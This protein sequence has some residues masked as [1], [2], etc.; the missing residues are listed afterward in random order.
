M[1]SNIKVKRICVYCSREFIAQTTSTKYCSKKCNSAHYKAKVRAKKVE[2]SNIETTQKKHKPIQDVQAKE[3]LSVKDVSLLL[4][5]SKHSIYRL[6]ENGTLKAVNLAER[7]TRVNKS[8]VNK[9]LKQSEPQLIIEESKPVY[10]IKAP[11]QIQIDITDCYYMTEIQKKYG[12]S[13]KAL[14]DIIKRNSIPKLKQ[15]WYSYVPKILI[16]ELLT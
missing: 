13:E 16:D 2:R 15:G 7:M 4:G 11:E 6:I 5:C 1:S 14:H 12:I 10:V 9:L 3:F 8:E